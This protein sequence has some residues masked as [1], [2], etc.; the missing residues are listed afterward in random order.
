MLEK[1]RIA[2]YA[3]IVFIA[4]MASLMVNHQGHAGAFLGTRDLVAVLRP[5]ISLKARESLAK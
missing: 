2:I 4:T 3:T 5:N 1:S